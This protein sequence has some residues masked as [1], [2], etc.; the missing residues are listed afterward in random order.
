MSDYQAPD[1]ERWLIVKLRR[2]S[3]QWPARYESIRRARIEPGVYQCNQCKRPLK[4]KEL[5]VDHINPVKDPRK[6]KVTLLQFI[7]SLFCDVENLQV[8][9]KECHEVKSA[10]ENTVRRKTRG[11]NGTKL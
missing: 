9:C 1:L 8:L 5:H 11:K 4:I 6:V 2:L 10:K 3:L 7:Q